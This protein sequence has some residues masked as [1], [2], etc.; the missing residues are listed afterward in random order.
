MAHIVIM[1]AGLGGMPAAYEMREA[2]PKEHQVTVVSAVDY[3]QFVPSNPW[4]AVGWRTR[5]EV[6]MKV[7]PLLER[8]GIRFIAKP[9]TQIDADGSK[10]VLDGGQP[11]E[12][13]PGL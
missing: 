7:G 6:I 3:F 13:R 5:E 2:L 10:L 4:V 11:G 9:V 1:G 8:K 12:D